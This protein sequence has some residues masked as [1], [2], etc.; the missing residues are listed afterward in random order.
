MKITTAQLKKIIVEE[1]N[2]LNEVE[3]LPP[4]LDLGSMSMSQL[5]VLKTQL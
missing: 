5:I 1:L 2:G 4:G 3:M